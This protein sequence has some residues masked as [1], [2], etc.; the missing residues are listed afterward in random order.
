MTFD[1]A[2]HAFRPIATLNPTVDGGCRS[3]NPF[4]MRRKRPQT[5]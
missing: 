3:A 1:K 2:E 4:N 5:P